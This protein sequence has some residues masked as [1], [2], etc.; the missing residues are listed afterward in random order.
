MAVQI[1]HLRLLAF[2]FLQIG[3]FANRQNAIAADRDGLFTNNGLK[4]TLGRDARVHVS[5][6]EDD[7]GLLR[8]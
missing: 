2:E 8:G 5:V 1:D 3:K 4:G 6:H 7:V